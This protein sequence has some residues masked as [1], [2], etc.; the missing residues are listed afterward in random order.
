MT[1][2]GHLVE[3]PPRRR[4]RVLLVLTLVLAVV[5]L[6]LAFLPIGSFVAGVP[7]LAAIVLAVVALVRGAQ[8][9]LPSIGVVLAVVAIVVAVVVS[10]AQLGQALVRLQDSLPG[11][12]DAPGSLPTP[13]PSG[14]SGS[15]SIGALATGPHRVVYEVLG[16]GAARVAYS[17]ILDGRTGTSSE[18]RVTVPHSRT[19]RVTIDDSGRAARFT[20]IA[21]RGAE[22]D[23]ALGC[24]ITID[25]RV[26]NER[27]PGGAS[28][29]IAICAV[30]AGG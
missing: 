13:A 2:P 19:Q 17:A 22:D 14:S 20:M 18:R 5:A 28:V 8:R 16:D 15:G 7:A 10:V 24:R 4:G 3:A 6:V 23:G 1:D 26:V 30:T 21:T 25:G 12:D 11:L 27:A 9:L 29:P